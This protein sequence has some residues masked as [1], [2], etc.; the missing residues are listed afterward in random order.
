MPNRASAWLRSDT[1]RLSPNSELL[2]TR[3]IL[4]GQRG[5][6]LDA[7][8]QRPGIHLGILGQ[9]QDL[10]RHGR[11]AVELTCGGNETFEGAWR[12]AHGGRRARKTLGWAN[13]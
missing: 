12:V 1:S 3:R 2:T 10:H 9:F 11:Q 13:M 6:V 5:I 8:L 7:L 4:P